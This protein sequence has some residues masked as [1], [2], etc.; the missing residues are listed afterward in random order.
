MKRTLQGE[1]RYEPDSVEGR[2]A[3]SKTVEEIRTST[4][5]IGSQI[6][7]S[8]VSI[9][10]R[11][12]EQ[13]GPTYHSML[14]PQSGIFCANFLLA[15]NLHS[16]HEEELL[17]QIMQILVQASKRWQLVK[18]VTQMLLKGSEE[19]VK[20]LSSPLAERD[21][22]QSVVP[23][24]G[25]ITKELFESME[26]IVKDMAWSPSDYLHFSSRYPNYLVAKEDPTVELS[27]MLEQWAQLALEEIAL[28][29]GEDENVEMAGYDDSNDNDTGPQAPPVQSIERDDVPMADVEEVEDTTI[30]ADKESS[31]VREE[32]KSGDNLESAPAQSEILPQE[33]VEQQSKAINVQKSGQSNTDTP[34]TAI[35]PQEQKPQADI[36]QTEAGIARSTSESHTAL[37]A[38]EGHE[39]ADNNL[40][41]SSAVEAGAAG[42]QLPATEGDTTYTTLEDVAVKQ[43]N[44]GTTATISEQS[45]G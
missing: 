18:G 23:A 17:L 29:E 32:I 1:A 37:T 11:F 10:R 30:I 40:D 12:D 2:K 35:R 15:G 24:P 14:M 38:H 4:L 43:G 36:S 22:E 19:K 41:K 28:R 5:A 26:L 21:D 9:G 27:N 16:A 45:G 34:E 8:V 42:K 31:K 44:S 39:S 7:E 6:V 25:K 33:P 3:G 13:Y 20:A